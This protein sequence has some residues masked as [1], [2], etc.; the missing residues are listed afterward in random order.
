V[1]E[2]IRIDT[3]CKEMEKE[4][5]DSNSEDEAKGMDVHLGVER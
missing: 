4:W 2:P 3:E 1:P 5:T